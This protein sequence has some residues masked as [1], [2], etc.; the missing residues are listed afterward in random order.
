[1][2]TNNIFSITRFGHLIKRYFVLNFRQLLIEN[3]AAIG[4]LG[5]VGGLTLHHTQQSGHQVLVI[6]FYLLM[7][8]GGLIRTS[9]VF[10]ELHKPEK[11]IQF[12]TL[13]ASSF[14]KL[15]SAWLNTT[16]LFTII[17]IVAFHIAY[18]LSMLFSAWWFKTSVEW[19]N[20]FEYEIWKVIIGYFLIHTIFLFGS[21]YF[22]G[23]NFFKTIFSLFVLFLV[24]SIYHSLVGSAAMHEITTLL[25]EENSVDPSEVISAPGLEEY[26]NSTLQPIMKALFYYIL[27][28][29]FLVLSY[30]KLKEREA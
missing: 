27:P 5:I 29:F 6:W 8:V 7:I 11:S 22:K 16:V 4:F 15:L 13:P 19:V 12:L 2:D 23:K 3:L 25:F 30:I 18:P 1:M 14:E 24:F 26:V 10:S 17:S 9:N 28:T 20:I 21:V